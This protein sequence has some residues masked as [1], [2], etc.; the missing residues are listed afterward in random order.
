MREM[1]GLV[2]SIIGHAKSKELYDVLEGTDTGADISQ[3]ANDVIDAS[4]ISR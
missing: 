3:F 4:H 1:I 2:K